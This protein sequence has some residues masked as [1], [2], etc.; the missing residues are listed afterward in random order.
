MIAALF[1]VAI[2]I[3]M[4]FRRQPE[5]DNKHSEKIGFGSAFREL[6]EAG[7][8]LRGDSILSLNVLFTAVNAMMLGGFVFMIP[9]FV[10]EVFDSG[11]FGLGLIFA[12]TGIGAFAGALVVATRGGIDAAG[13]GL[14]VSNLLFAGAAILFTLTEQYRCRC[15]GG[16]LLWTLQRLSRGA[17]DLDDPGE[18]SR[19]AQRQ[20]DR[21]L[22][23]RMGQ[24]P[25]WWIGSGVYRRTGRSARSVSYCWRCGC[26]IDGRSVFAKPED[27]QPESEPTRRR[28]AWGRV[29]TGIQC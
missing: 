13:K 15:C 8:V 27:A 17:R 26:D 14:V 2:I 24:L 12:T 21:C 1:G 7:V 16:I 4:T 23:A 22:R 20:G 25:A 18:C 11:E 3:Y 28:L 10:K 5:T 6:K 9:A 19:P 29:A